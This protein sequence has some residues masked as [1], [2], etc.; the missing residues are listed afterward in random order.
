M[1]LA[2][3]MSASRRDQRVAGRWGPGVG[4]VLLVRIYR[5]IVLAVPSPLEELAVPREDGACSAL[6]QRFGEQKAW[7]SLVVVTG[8][9]S[10][11]VRQSAAQ[12]APKA[13]P[14][15]A[16]GKGLAVPIDQPVL[17]TER[18]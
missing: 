3:A 18:A 11:L 14:Y 5:L 16:E 8:L 13:P 6:T 15:A 10:V 4:R 1:L 9:L 12:M 17:D 2:R 7:H